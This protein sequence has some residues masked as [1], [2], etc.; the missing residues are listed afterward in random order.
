[1]KNKEIQEQRM[2]QYFIQATKDILK[3]EGLKCV[4]V[5]NVAERA[6]YSY[7]TLYNY[8]SD[9]KDLIF[10]CVKD[11]LEECEE[12]VFNEVKSSSRGLKR[13]KQILKAYIKYFIQ[14]PGIFEL[15]FLEKTTELG[16]KKPTLKMIYDFLDKL[17][18]DDWNYCVKKKQLKARDAAAMRDT[19]HHA[20]IGMLLF[21]I[22]RR[23]PETYK[24][25]TEITEAQLNYILRV[26]K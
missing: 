7:A 2:K 13:I 26:K 19:A 25:F 6:G 15:F 5:R 4:S 17:C 10:E 18:E 16:Y 14:Y 9:A 3:G 8:F 22:N 23:Q 12:F 21:Y 1:M 11:F 24:E 20:V